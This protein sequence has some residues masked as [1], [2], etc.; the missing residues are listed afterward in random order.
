MSAQPLVAV[1]GPRYGADQR[2]QL[3]VAD[4][5]DQSVGFDPL[6]VLR[7]SL[8]V[9]LAENAI[10]PPQLARRSLAGVLGARL[11]DGRH[12]CLGLCRRRR[13]CCRRL[14]GGREQLLH[15]QVLDQLLGPRRGTAAGL[16]DHF[17]R[18]LGGHLTQSTAQVLVRESCLRHRVPYL[19]REFPLE[20]RDL[21]LPGE[22][23]PAACSRRSS[24][25]RSDLFSCSSA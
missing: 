20:E 12:R 1:F 24:R 6:E 9:R 23:R 10:R 17:R 15:E 7:G 5:L 25:S 16:L 14:R 13:R 4:H 3:T 2:R 22:G 19:L 18:C 21:S 8:G 11:R